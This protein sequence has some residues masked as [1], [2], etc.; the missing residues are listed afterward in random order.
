MNMHSY[1]TPIFKKVLDV[2][3]I[4]ITAYFISYIFLK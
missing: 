2:R 1:F 3:L 4:E